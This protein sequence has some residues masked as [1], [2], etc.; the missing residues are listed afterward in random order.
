MDTI[1]VVA[2]VIINNN[3]FFAAER[4]YGEYA[5]YWEFP[6]GK[7]EKGETPEQALVREI[8]EELNVQISID[9]FL[10]DVEYDYPK[11]HLFMKSYI[12]HIDDGDITLLEHKTAIWMDIGNIKAMKWLPSAYPIL[13]KLA[14]PLY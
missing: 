11:F 1:N 9:R 10:I 14:T 8:K 7:I 12:C 5:G 3:Q 2:A 13:E 6:G 4:G